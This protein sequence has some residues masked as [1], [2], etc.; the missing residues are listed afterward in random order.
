MQKRKQRSRE[1]VLK[2]KK[3]KTQ[4]LKTFDQGF[5]R[6]ESEVKINLLEN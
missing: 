3:Y 6:I 1:R 2:S 4:H 5:S